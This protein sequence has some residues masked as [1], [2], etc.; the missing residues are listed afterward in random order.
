MAYD[1]ASFLAGLAVGQKLKGWGA[2]GVGVATDGESTETMADPY[3]AVGIGCES[4]IVAWEPF[5][6]IFESEEEAT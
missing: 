6:A 4:V 2:Y 1:K 3:V 5:V